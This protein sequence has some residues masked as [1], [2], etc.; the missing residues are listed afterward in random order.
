M[1]SRELVPRGAVS[2]WPE[3][4]KV[5]SE[6]CLGGLEIFSRPRRELSR[7]VFAG[8]LS[9][10]PLHRVAWNGAPRHTPACTKSVRVP[11]AE[12]SSRAT[13][14]VNRALPLQK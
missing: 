9:V 13:P 2:E 3:S 7:I 14:W 11:L 5:V 6:L 4:R 8:H 10:H 12:R 1:P